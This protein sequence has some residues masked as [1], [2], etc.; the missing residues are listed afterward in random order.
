MIVPIDTRLITDWNS[1]HDVFARA[2]GFPDYYGRNL[3]AWIDCMSSLNDPENTDNS[4][5]AKPGEIV[6]LHFEHMAEFKN[7]C[8]KQYEAIIEC[9]AFVNFRAIVD[10]YEPV[11]ALSFHYRA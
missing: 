7:R 3:D 1:F 9:A 4:V 11:L 6:V 10:G 5:R 2:L 8:Q